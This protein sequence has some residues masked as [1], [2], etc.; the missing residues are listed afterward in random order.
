MSNQENRRKDLPL[1]TI[2]VS[3]YNREYYLPFC[4]DSL[5]SQTYPNC[6]IIVVDDGSTDGTEKLMKER[7]PHIKYF[8][9]ENGGDGSAKNYVARVA[10][11]E[12]I[13]FNDSDDMFLPD[14]VERLYNALDPEDENSCSYGT[15]QTIDAD[16][17]E[18]PTKQK[19]A[20]YPSGNITGAL[21]KHIIVNSCGTLMP[22]QFFLDRGGFDTNLRV[23]HDWSL[24]LEMSLH[25]KFYGVRE[26]VFLRRRHGNNISSASYEKMKIVWNVFEKFLL[27]HPE[28][29]SQF[30]EI[31][32]ER[33]NDLYGKLYREAKREKLYSSALTHAAAAWDLKKSGKNFFRLLGA[34]LAVKGCCS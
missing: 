11:G 3:A 22:R 18:M 24:F 32:K 8:R 4:L 20:N 23:C 31:V 25:C 9:K 33:R 30:A 26:P 13:V 14:T 10:S 7:Y 12:Y 1:I 15:Y 5:L 21:L 27:R 28:V 2:G 29:G 34:W 19:M 16:G 17:N 6:E